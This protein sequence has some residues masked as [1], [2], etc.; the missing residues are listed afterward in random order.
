MEQLHVE[1]LEALHLQPAGH[2]ALDEH[3]SD[4]GRDR[5]TFSRVLTALHAWLEANGRREPERA[6]ERRFVPERV[7]PAE[8]ADRP[9]FLGIEHQ[10]RDGVD[11]VPQPLQH[12]V[13]LVAAEGWMDRGI[14]EQVDVLGEP[15]E[16]T[17]AFGQ[18]GS[19]LEHGP[20]GECGRDDTEDL[21][22]PVVLLDEGLLEL[23]RIGCR[24]HERREVRVLVQ[25]HLACHSLACF[26]TCRGPKSNR[27]S[28]LSV[29]RRRPSS[30][31]GA[32]ASCPSAPSIARTRGGSL[33]AARVRRAKRFSSLMR[34]TSRRTVSSGERS[35]GRPR[36]RSNS[37]SAASRSS[38]PC[39][40]SGR[41]V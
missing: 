5:A 8:P 12:F 31:F 16:Q 38:R 18:A 4:Q 17:P 30:R 39:L 14:D 35:L 36:S 2:A 6:F 22:N 37:S 26:R 24:R 21:G 41:R 3:R 29:L 15:V 1:G 7:H 10:T 25:P 11:V 20:L 23:G 28:G 13:D 33:S 40:A 9:G 27:E 32:S 34:R 19:S